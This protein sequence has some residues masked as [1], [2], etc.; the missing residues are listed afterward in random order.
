MGIAPRLLEILEEL[1]FT[2]PTPIQAQAIPVILEK[3]DLVG[4][5]QTGTGKTL[6][7]GVPMLQLLASQKG[8]G[9]AVLP[10]RELAA[11][12]DESLRTIGK[13]IGLR[14]AVLIGGEKASK[15]LKDL[16]RKPH[17]VIATPGRL[18]DLA[19]RKAVD[20]KQVRILVLDEADMMLDMGFLPQIRQIL[21]EVPTERQT[22]L[23]SATMPDAISQIA[24]RYMSV[25]FRVEVAPSGT[26]AENVKQEI[27][28]VDQ[29]G[30]F[31]QLQNVL[32]ECKGSV[33]VFAR[34]KHGV[35]NLTRK[36]KT[37]GFSAAEI[38][39]DRSLAQ[40]Q[41]ALKGF[42]LGKYRILVAT[43]IA[44]RGIDVQGIEL[45]VNFDLPNNSEDYVHRIGR[46]GRAGLMGRAIS[47]ALISQLPDIRSIEKLTR[48]S[49]NVTSV[50]EKTGE[51]TP[52]QRKK[53]SGRSSARRFGSSRR[54][55]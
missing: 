50:S 10:T 8:M 16:K 51:R 37:A 55:R 27:I 47:F 12:V 4:I 30:K 45:V 15:Q 39:S 49:I 29:A 32:G 20:L 5:A 22:M 40:R 17:I 2:S 6:A 11:Q 1:D 53:P 54:R 18:I 42:K 44:A 14:T 9:L 34:T 13:K 21:K 31:P 23:F 26:A 52:I 3:K 25:P 46:T 36:L 38:H 7:F 19:G 41:E 33:L 24:S 43:D 28:I 48:Q 35:K